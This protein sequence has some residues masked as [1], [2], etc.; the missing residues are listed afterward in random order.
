[1]AI[2]FAMPFLGIVAYFLFG[3][4]NIGRQYRRRSLQA[5]LVLEDFAKEQGIDFNEITPYFVP[6]EALLLALTTAAKRGIKVTLNVPKKVDSK[7]VH[8]ASRAY[9]QPLL[10]AGVT[11]ALFTGAYCTPKL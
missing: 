1:M 5:Q 11:I 7:L 9:Y 6:D 4:T 8:Y 10:D 2:L 3:E